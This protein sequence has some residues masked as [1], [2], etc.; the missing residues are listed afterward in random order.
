[1]KNT[2]TT[3]ALPEILNRDLQSKWKEFCEAVDKKGIC[4]PDDPESNESLKRVFCFSD[5]VTKS[6]TRFPEL[7]SDLINSG[8]L[9][10]VYPPDNYS[11]M[12]RE[13]LSTV[14]D[15]LQLQTV[16]RKIRMR[17]MTRI[18]WRDLSGR[19]D[20][21]EVM[22]DLS[23]FADACIEHALLRLYQWQCRTYGTPV[24]FDG[25][26][27][28]LVVLGMGKLGACELNFSSDIDLIFAYPDA[29][30]T[31]G[32]AVPISNDEFFLK[33]CRKL[34]TVLG[35]TTA[36]GPMFRVDMRLR[37][38]GDSGALAM[39]FEAMEDYYQWQGREWERYAWIKARVAA[40][41]K[42]AG[43]RLLERLKPFVY[44]R[45]LDFGAFDSLR[46]MKHSIALEVKRKDLKDN[47]KL[48]PGGIREIEFFGQIFQLIRAGVTP[49]LQILCIQSVLQILAREHYIPDQVY[50]ELQ[51]AY[52][53]L[54]N[55]EHRLQEFSDLQTHKLPSDPAGR[56]RIAASMGF[57]GFESFGKQLSHHRTRV[58]HHFNELLAGA[59]S[60]NAED[61][62]RENLIRLSG[63]WHH[64]LKDESGEKVLTDA[65][66]TDI[67]VVTGLMDFLKNDSATR[68]LSREGRDRLDKLVPLILKQVGKVREPEAV[69]NQIVDLIKTIEQRTCYLALLLENPTALVHLVKLAGA[70]HLIVSFLRQHP[71]LLDELLDPRSLYAPPGKQELQS[72]LR[73]RL[74]QVPADDLEYQMETLRIFKQVNLLRVAAADITEALPLMKVSDHLSYIAEA[75]L[76]EVLELSWNHLIQKHGRPVCQ[77]DDESAGNGFAVIAYGKL[78]GIEL[79]YASDLDLVFLHSGVPGQAT[80]GGD[81][82]IDNTSFYAR[83]GQRFIHILTA[84]TQAGIL[85]ETDMRLRPSGSAGILVSHIESFEAYQLETAWA[86]EHQAL[87]KTRAITGDPR[88][89][90]RFES[91]R[92]AVLS[93]PRDKSSLRKDVIDMRNRLGK[94]LLVPDPDIFDLKQGPGGMVDIEFL[95]QY[96]VLLNACN[97]PELTRWT[98]NVRLLQTLASTKIMDPSTALFLRKAY[99][100]YRSV[101][102]RLSLQEK[103]ARVEAGQFA[104]V[105]KDITRI[106]K[107]VFDT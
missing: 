102:H 98:D 90:A 91:I 99:L 85:Y 65:G 16:L 63:I 105:R 59:N 4:L 21:N 2:V 54:R 15:Q 95:V 8:D 46:D 32:S 45:Y 11:H 1:M 55:T 68:S 26:Q 37:P 43:K 84:H 12:I 31:T 56:E 13:K 47:I 38:Y 57:D 25:S 96:L 107:K 28:Q 73:R 7:A 71:V 88:L 10:R 93:A 69:L 72:E 60:G 52:I 89:T 48:G 103:P 44:R 61:P 94:E 18:A 92:K 51:D 39:S 50:E 14:D 17:E 79:G 67:T 41:D 82:P 6:C 75:V 53:F 34:I 78:G 77:P 58:Q 97:H 3:S 19:A 64:G 106:W 62:D 29:G 30:E 49:E 101:A 81:R 66:F 36:D 76:D 9:D 35:T 74:K 80:R 27:G 22:R 70:S 23:A 5:F 104:D 20:L 87:V 42:A 40:G 86:W 33:L 24:S 83:L 100:S